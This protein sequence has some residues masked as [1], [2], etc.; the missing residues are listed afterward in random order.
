MVECS[1]FY[2]KT[3]KVITHVSNGSL[4]KEKTAKFIVE[5]TKVSTETQPATKS[6]SENTVLV[7][8]TMFQ[9]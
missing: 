3:L 2:I 9:V 7:P 4:E 6:T 8:G 5:I 1:S